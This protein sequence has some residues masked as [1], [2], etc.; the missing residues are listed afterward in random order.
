VLL[1]RLS[2]S[3]SNLSKPQDGEAAKRLDALTP[4]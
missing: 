3:T 1:C 2:E 4:P